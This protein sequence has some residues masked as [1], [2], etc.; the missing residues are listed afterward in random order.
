MATGQR[1][2][3]TSRILEDFPALNGENEASL[4]IISIVHVFNSC[5]KVHLTPSTWFNIWSHLSSSKPSVP[6]ITEFA[7]QEQN[8]RKH[9]CG[10]N[11]KQI[12][13]KK[14]LKKT[15]LT[16]TT[17]EYASR[18][19]IHGIGYVF[20]GE[21]NILDRLLWL[22]VVLAFLGIAAALSWNFWSQWRNEQVIKAN[23]SSS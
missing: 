2:E 5:P 21:L 8:C 11:D 18:S 14:T 1:L 19:S 20:D 22:L 3:R 10:G 16:Q 7:V 6:I 15:A 17:E 9:C 13:M 23:C 12:N 4:S